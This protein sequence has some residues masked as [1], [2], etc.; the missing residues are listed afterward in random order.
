MLG[1]GGA[2]HGK[3]APVDL[4]GEGSVGTGLGTA[5]VFDAQ[6][7]GFA[8]NSAGTIEGCQGELDADF[9]VLAVDVGIAGEG[10]YG[11]NGNPL[12]EIDRPL[13]V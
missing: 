3:H 6:G 2:D 11:S 10:Q 4:Q 8:V 9:L 13:I 5:P 1:E 12:A 7:E